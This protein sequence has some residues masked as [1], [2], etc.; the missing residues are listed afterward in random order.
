MLPQKSTLQ[1]C[2][3]SEK[4]VHSNWKNRVESI[5]QLQYELGKV[6]CDVSSCDSYPNPAPV[7]THIQAPAAERV[8]VRLRQ[9]RAAGAGVDLGW[10][11]S[12]LS[13]GSSQAGFEELSCHLTHSACLQLTELPMGNLGNVHVRGCEAVGHPPLGLCSLLPE[14]QPP[15]TADLTPRPHVSHVRL[16]GAQRQDRI[17]GRVHTLAL[18]LESP[19]LATAAGLDRLWSQVE[20]MVLVPVAPWWPSLLGRQLYHTVYPITCLDA[21]VTHAAL[22]VKSC[23]WAINDGGNKI[24]VYSLETGQSE[25]VVGNSAGDFSC[26][27]KHTHMRCICNLALR[28]GER[29]KQKKAFSSAF[30]PDSRAGVGRVRVFDLRTGSS[31][32]SLYAHHMGVTSVQADDWKIVSGRGEGLVC[33]WEMRMGAKLWHPVRHVRFNTS[34]LVT[35]NI[36][37]EKSSRWGLHHRPRPHSPPQ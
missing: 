12:S 21:S 25:V 2:R 30:V 23:G 28:M 18:S 27:L 17:P 20:S 29:N 9:P 6:L 26:T 24:Q 15:L 37:D 7:L 33:V 32:T 13:R 5:S 35:A 16:C 1:D 36:P 34:S 22:G 8:S 19:I 31:V 10:T 3:N 11:W 4:T 14:A